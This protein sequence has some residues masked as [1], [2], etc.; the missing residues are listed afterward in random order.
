MHRMRAQMRADR[1]AA[2]GDLRAQLRASTQGPEREHLAVAI[3]SLEAAFDEA[4]R[5]APEE[6][7]AFFRKQMDDFERRFVFQEIGDGD[8]ADFGGLCGFARKPPYPPRARARPPR[9]R[10]EEGGEPA[11]ATPSPKPK[12]LIGGA[13][14]P[15]E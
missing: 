3:T 4:E 10:P 7:D 5:R 8:D 11:M 1:N 2:L 12:P 15:I 6:F 9:R 14:A 13:E